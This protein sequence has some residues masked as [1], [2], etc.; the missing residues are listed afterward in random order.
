MH[1]VYALAGWPDLTLGTW[2][3]HCRDLRDLDRPKVVQQRGFTCILAPK[4]GHFWV[5]KRVSFDE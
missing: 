1:V 5:P 3:I 4:T 2:E